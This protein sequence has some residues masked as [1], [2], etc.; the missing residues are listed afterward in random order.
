MPLG[1]GDVLRTGARGRLRIRLNDSSLLSLGSSSTLRVVKH[2]AGSQ[3]TSLEL[4]YGRIRCRVSKLTGAGAS[5]DLRTPTA[6]AGVIGTDFGADSS[7][8]DETRFVCVEGTVRV[9]NLDPRVAGSVDCTPR[10]TTLVRRGEPPTTPV[11]AGPGLLARWQ[12]IAEPGDSRFANT[13][14]PP[15]LNAMRLRRSSPVWLSQTS[16]Y[17]GLRWQG[18]NLG[19]RLRMRGE[20]WDWFDPGAGNSSYAFA[21]STLRIS[22]GHQGKR[23]AWQVELAQPSV[24]AAPGT[25]V[26]P[27]PQGQMGLGATYYAANDNSRYAAAFFPSQAFLRFPRLKGQA[28]NQLT[29]GRFR[30]VEGLETT[31]AE[32]VLAWLKQAR[33]AHRLLGDFDFSAAGRT[34]DGLWLEW[35]VPAGQLTFAAARPTA[36]VFRM[37]GASSLDVL[38]G[39]AALTLPRLAQR[40]EVRLFAL[41]YGDARALVKSDNRPLALRSGDDRFQNIALGTFGGHYIE[42]FPAGSAGSFDLLFWG[43]L[44]AGSWGTQDHRAGAFAAEVGWQPQFPSLRPWLRLGYYR[45]SGD[46]DPLDSTHRTFFQVLPTPRLYARYPFYNGQNISDLS[47]MALLR[48]WARLTLRSE[49]H[50]LWLAA[51]NDLWYSGGGAFSRTVFG[52]AGRPSGGHSGLAR[53]WDLSTDFKLSPHW[54]LGV[55]YARAWGGDVVKQSFPADPGS[56]YAFLESTFQF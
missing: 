26:L 33:L 19:A 44:Q 56:N 1:W 16:A 36:G 38:W 23:L 30:F 29:L 43:A 13:L 3:Q 8:P 54:S 9:R 20:A 4:G 28:G 41:G 49:T 27:A 47:F 40:R 51:A 46:D 24:L 53:V 12:H 37:N 14:P 55:Y 7:T 25:A 2:D 10:M 35:Q 50:A 22:L 32:P 17:P 18:V 34:N 11:P 39:Y 15:D 42:V 5:F 45:S 52:Y 6:V 31:P 48:P 21:H